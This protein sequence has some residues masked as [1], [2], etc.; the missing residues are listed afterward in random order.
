MTTRA[1]IRALPLVALLICALACDSEPEGPAEQA[2]EIA[3][4]IKASPDDA[5]EILEDHE[6]SIEEFEAMMY[7]I[8]ADPDLSERYQALLESEE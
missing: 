7:E 4:E 3:R 2:A 5:E 8:A 6:M 1:L